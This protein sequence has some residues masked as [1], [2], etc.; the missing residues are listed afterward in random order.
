MVAYR[1]VHKL[2]GKSLSASGLPG[3]WNG[4]GK[5]VIYC[6]ESIALAFLE[7][8]VRRQGVGF[9][10]D[11]CTMIIDIP[12]DLKI[13]IVKPVDL[14][15]GWRNIRDYSK[16]QPVGNKW[17]DQKDFPV[18][19]VP[20]AILPVENNFVINTLHKG[21]NKIKVIEIAN[22]LPDIKIENILKMNKIR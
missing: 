15:A 13:S 22:L 12:D 17:Y 8:M 5:K 16:C 18:L 1:L 14:E 20:S 9:N 7:N 6:A 10:K 3:R 11:F 2:Y 4:A 21:F 19:K